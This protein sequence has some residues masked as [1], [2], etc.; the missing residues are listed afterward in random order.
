MVYQNDWH[1]IGI[2]I[3]NSWWILECSPV[4]CL[5]LALHSLPYLVLFCNLLGKA[6]E[7]IFQNV[8]LE[9]CVH[10]QALNH[11]FPGVG[12]HIVYHFILSRSLRFC[13]HSGHLKLMDRWPQY[14][15]CFLLLACH[16]SD[17]S[18]L[19]TRDYPSEHELELY[20]DSP[21]IFSFLQ[22]S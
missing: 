11:K 3:L 1:I 12:N 5:C 16:Y 19:F 4:L 20:F 9:W 8:K 13:M 2:K 18:F 7:V 14:F 15:R 21:E 6:K 22:H 10:M 17:F